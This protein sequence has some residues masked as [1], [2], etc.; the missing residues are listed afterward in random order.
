MES[1]DEGVLNREWYCCAV[2]VRIAG[3]EARTLVCPFGVRAAGHAEALALAK[4]TAISISKQRPGYDRWD[5]W[6]NDQ[7]EGGMVDNPGAIQ[8]K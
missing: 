2:G 6:V 8:V 1:L 5:V 4:L 7:A 3:G